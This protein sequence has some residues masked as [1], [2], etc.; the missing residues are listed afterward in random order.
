M[1][2]TSHYVDVLVPLAAAGR[3]VGGVICEIRAA[4]TDRAAEAR[5]GFDPAIVPL[6]DVKLAGAGQRALDIVRRLPLPKR[7]FGLPMRLTRPS[8][9]NTLMTP[10]DSRQARGLDPRNASSAE[11]GLALSLCL[12]ERGRK[13][14]V[15]FATGSLE[16]SDFDSV[17]PNDGPVGPVEGLS[18]KFE[19]V[20]TW[21]ERHKVGPWG[22]HATLFVPA[23]TVDGS[24]TVE[25]YREEI[26]R[27]RTRAAAI[28]VELTVTPLRS[29]AEGAR[30]LGAVKPR[31]DAKEG[32]MRAGVL[33]VLGF[34]AFMAAA[35]QPVE[36]SPGKID[37]FLGPLPTPT[38]LRASVA[39]EKGAKT[40]RPVPPCTT[41]TGL[42]LVQFEDY[43]SVNIETSQTMLPK[44][45]FS[46]VFVVIGEKSQPKI[47]EPKQA[48]NTEAD[49]GATPIRKV[50]GRLSFG[51]AFP[52]QPPEE[53]MK[54]VAL[55]RQL[56]GF[57]TNRLDQGVRETFEN[58]PQE[59]RLNAQARWLANIRGSYIE[60]P[61][62]AVAPDSQRV[63]R[64]ES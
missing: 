1:S 48:L 30:H 41:K 57:N 52:V 46:A 7:R 29:L 42:S 49:A 50:N 6:L 44:S 28:G 56:G 35:L 8:S 12:L 54:I 3:D 61:F 14:G 40:F 27:A 36:L 22:K 32:V 16:G 4:F 51:A 9:P 60:I 55:S 26:E 5:G 23:R 63:V 25:A 11:L 53:E 13:P 39:D 24:L 10:L 2:T 18:Q 38:V 34:V 64:C 15:F 43:V 20:T 21:L 37:Y 59:T 17:H 62:E 19:A 58:V 45:L 47:F 31:F 33:A